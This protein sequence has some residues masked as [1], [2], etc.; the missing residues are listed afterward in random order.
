MVKKRRLS[1][2]CSGDELMKKIKGFLIF[3]S[4]IAIIISVIAVTC[5]YF[6]VA[7]NQ[8]NGQEMEL[9]TDRAYA[10]RV[11]QENKMKEIMVHDHLYKKAGRN[12][13]YDKQTEQQFIIE[14]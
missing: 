8:K 11:L 1:I 9:K 7:E 10:Y 4:F 6:A 2:K 13:I 12:R 3:E 14:K 5:F